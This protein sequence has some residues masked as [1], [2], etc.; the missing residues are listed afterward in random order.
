MLLKEAMRG[1]YADLSDNFLSSSLLTSS[2]SSVASTPGNSSSPSLPC[3]NLV[4]VSPPM[5]L[6]SSLLP[7]PAGAPTLTD[8]ATTATT[9]T[10]P[11]PQFSIEA[12]IS[13]LE[14]LTQ[15]RTPKMRA[16]NAAQNKR[17]RDQKDRS[18]AKYAGASSPV[19]TPRTPKSQALHLW[20]W[21]KGIAQPR[22]LE[23][24][25][26]ADSAFLL[27]LQEWDGRTPII[28]ADRDGHIIAILAGRPDG[29]S[30]EDVQREATELLEEARRQCRVPKKN[31]CQ[32]RGTF[33]TLRCGFSHGGGQTRPQNLS[34]SLVE[35]CPQNLPNTKQKFRITTRLNKSRAMRR[36]AGFGS[37]LVKFEQPILDRICDATRWK[38]TLISGG[39]QLTFGGR[40]TVVSAHSGT[41]SGDIKTNLALS[42]PFQHDLSLTQGLALEDCGA[43]AREPGSD[44]ERISAEMEKQ[45]VSADAV[46]EVEAGQRKLTL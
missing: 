37:C 2:G 8:L 9:P 21:T 39:P 45:G 35:H 4:N 28:I 46:T 29:K 15:R 10:P 22:S 12:L 13:Q 17:K 11:L 14:V 27:G 26:G 36:L 19:H 42:I 41:T 6:D 1:G 3:P 30:W 34:L 18:K 23:D 20:G 16:P 24:L 5:S 33:T 31:Q 44:V 38:C 40:L 43:F 32:R 25:L 7:I